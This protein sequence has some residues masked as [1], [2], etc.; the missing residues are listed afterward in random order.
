MLIRGMKVGNVPTKEFSGTLIATVF[1][2]K[3]IK[4][5]RVEEIL[6]YDERGVH[7]VESNSVHIALTERV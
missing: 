7:S 6:D 2:K 4:S 3:K 5:I 1:D